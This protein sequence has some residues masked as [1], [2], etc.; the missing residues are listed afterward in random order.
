VW[1]TIADASPD[2]DLT[3]TLSFLKA[4]ALYFYWKICETCCRNSHNSPSLLKPLADPEKGLC[5]DPPVLEEY[6]T[7]VL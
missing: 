2:P 3:Q 6:L 4:Q 1:L 7:A 5:M